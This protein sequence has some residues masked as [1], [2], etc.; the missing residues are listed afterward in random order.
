MDRICP[1]CLR[2]FGRMKI[3]KYC[4][5]TLEPELEEI[6]SLWPAAKRFEMARVFKRWSRQ[7]NISAKIMVSG[8]RGRIFP[9]PSLPKVARR[10][11]SLN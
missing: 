7:L 4:P 6:A 2:K 3:E 1:T 11:A 9:R 5:V 8:S 10:K